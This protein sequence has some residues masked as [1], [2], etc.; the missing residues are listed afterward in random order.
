MGAAT[1][2]TPRARLKVPLICLG[3]LLAALAVP[4]ILVGSG[5]PMLT[6]PAP[7][8][9][10]LVVPLPDG[11][12]T[13]LGAL[14]DGTAPQPQRTTRTVELESRDGTV[15]TFEVRNPPVDLYHVG[16]HHAWQGNTQLA[17]ECLT[18]IPRGHP[19]WSRAQ[20]FLGLRVYARNGDPAT[21]VAYVHRALAANPLEGNAWQDAA[22][23]YL[24][25]MGIDSQ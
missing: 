15:H 10:T 1:T 2:T 5:A 19:D 16:T 11:S 21:G 9:R 12:E 17:I 24:A 13:T 3:V 14:L 4:V 20:R 25:R 8:N 23:V 6:T 22:R 7:A 18:R